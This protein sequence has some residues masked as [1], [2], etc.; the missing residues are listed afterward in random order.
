MHVHFGEDDDDADYPERGSA[1]GSENAYERFFALCFLGFRLVLVA[2][3]DAVDHSIQRR[4]KDYL[5]QQDNRNRKEY[6]GY[7]VIGNHD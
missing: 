1:Q 6:L 2:S 4:A 3:Y 5:Y 7:G